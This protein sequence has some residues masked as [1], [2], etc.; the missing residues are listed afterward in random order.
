MVE[1]QVFFISIWRC[2]GDCQV[3]HLKRMKASVL[4]DIIKKQMV[5]AIRGWQTLAAEKGAKCQ[6]KQNCGKLPQLQNLHICHSLPFLLNP[7]IIS[8]L[9]S[10]WSSCS[11]SKLFSDMDRF[12]E[13]LFWCC[14]SFYSVSQSILLHSNAS[15]V[16]NRI[17]QLGGCHSDIWPFLHPFIASHHLSDW[18]QNIS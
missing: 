8:W 4:A 9:S 10:F 2:Q 5:A 1:M 3:F 15:E 13:T 6:G 11:I 7:L 17:S 18:L 12:N 16:L 14:G